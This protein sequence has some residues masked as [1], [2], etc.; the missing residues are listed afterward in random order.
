MCE[1]KQLQADRRERTAAN[2][3]IEYVLC[4]CGRIYEKETIAITHSID[5]D[6]EL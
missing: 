4:S 3:V 2:A 1:H 5:V 6:Y